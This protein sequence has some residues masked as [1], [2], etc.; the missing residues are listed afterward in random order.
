VRGE[1][2]GTGKIFRTWVEC[3][4]QAAYRQNGIESVRPSVQISKEK[5]NFE[6]GCLNPLICFQV[7]PTATMAVFETGKILKKINIQQLI[8][9][10]H[11]EV[12][13]SSLR[14]SSLLS[15]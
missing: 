11:D 7:V 8:L 2:E 5:N 4:N 10:L 6:P 1:G 14:H 13:L 3:L 15:F 9:C 12:L